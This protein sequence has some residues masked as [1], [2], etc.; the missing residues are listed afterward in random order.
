MMQLKQSPFIFLRHA[1]TDCNARRVIGGMTDSS[2]TEAGR[3]QA[4]AAAEKL[5]HKAVGK[6]VCS[7]LSRTRET[8][9]LALPDCEP[10]IEPGLNER[11]WGEL[12]GLPQDQVVPYKSTPPGGE[13]WDSFM[14]RVTVALNNL[15]K[16]EGTPLVVGHSGVYR[17]ICQHIVGR[18]DGPRIAN[19]EPVLVYYTASGWNITEL[20]SLA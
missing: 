13:P 4:R 7:A 10:Y 16:K 19:A 12:E 6:V 17:V 1:E 18:P 5:S 14:A 2:L 20:G 8:A 9:L 3:E 11:N 15:P